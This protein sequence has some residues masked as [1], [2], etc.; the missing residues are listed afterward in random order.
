[1][2][3]HT[4]T[5]ASVSAPAPIPPPAFARPP[6]PWGAGAPPRPDPDGGD[7]DLVGPPFRA[8]AR[9]HPQHDRDRAGLGPRP[10]IGQPLLGRVP[11]ALDPVPAEGVFPLR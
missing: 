10:G 11:P 2:S 3:C 7:G 4:N 8:P 9:H 6:N 5:C 1:M